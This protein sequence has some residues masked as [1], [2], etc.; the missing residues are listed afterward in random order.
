MLFKLQ[1]PCQLQAF[2]Q[3]TMMHDLRVQRISNA[4]NAEF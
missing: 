2:A 1:V 3:L 4:M